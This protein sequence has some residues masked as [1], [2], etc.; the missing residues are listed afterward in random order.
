MWMLSGVTAIVFAILNLSGKTDDKKTQWYRFSSLSLTALTL[1][2]FYFDG[3]V[4]V[5]R[6]DWAGLMDTMPALSRGL[7]FCTVA[8]ILIN[9][10]S[11]FKKND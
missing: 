3:A 11:L 5:T 2:A 6:E 7:L 1:Y 9:S 10:V 8:S 4:R